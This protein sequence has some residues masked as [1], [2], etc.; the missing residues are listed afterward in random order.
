M[1]RTNP[2]RC[3]ICFGPLDD[4]DQP[5]TLNC[6]GTCRGCMAWAGDPECIETLKTYG[7]SEAK[8]GRFYRG[9]S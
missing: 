8:N 4:S 6:G 5:H 3:D 1:T 9:L 2:R 7:Y